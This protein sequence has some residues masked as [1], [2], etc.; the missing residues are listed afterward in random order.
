VQ[1]LKTPFLEFEKMK[2]K[3][4]HY[5]KKLEQLR[6]KRNVNIAKNVVDSKSEKER[7]DRVQLFK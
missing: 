4:D 3:F 6:M 2:K 7:L 1:D 5:A